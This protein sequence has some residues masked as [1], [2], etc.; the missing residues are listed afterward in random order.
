MVQAVQDSGLNFEKDPLLKY[1]TGSLMGEDM[2]SFSNME[3][4]W[5]RIQRGARVSSFAMGSTLFGHISL[6]LGLKGPNFCFGGGGAGGALSIGHAA[7]W[8][9]SGICEV[10]LAG[11]SASAFSGP[12]FHGFAN[13]GVLS[14]RED[15]PEKASRPW[16]KDRDGFV[17]GEGAAVVVLEELEHAKKRGAK[18]YAEVAGIGQVS[19]AYHMARPEPEG[20]A[21]KKSMENALQEAGL[22]PEDIDYVNAHASGTRLGDRAEARAL[23]SLFKEGPLVSGTKSMTG[24]TL[25]AA[26]AIE[27]LFC[28]MSIRDQMVPPTINCDHPEASGLNVLTGTKAKSAK[29]DAALSNCIGLNGCVTSLV[30]RKY[31]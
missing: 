6:M 30:F 2:L 23:F 19:E 12:A 3:D 26:G 11:G 31:I 9:K 14:R 21:V 18:I 1:K 20:T 27:A 7:Y 4:S 13:M 24:H 5:H 10:M 17:L 15:D 29:V 22:P 8:I 16:D 25:G 28:V